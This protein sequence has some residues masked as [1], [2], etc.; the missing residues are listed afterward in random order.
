MKPVSGNVIIEDLTSKYGNDTHYVV[1]YYVEKNLQFTY[2]VSLI[3][4]SGDE[5][6]LEVDCIENNSPCS[7][8]FS[9]SDVANALASMG[10]SLSDGYIRFTFVPYGSDGSF[11]YAITFTDELNVDVISDSV[12]F[13]EYIGG[14]ERKSFSICPTESGYWIF[15][16]MAQYDSWAEITDKNGNQIACDDDN[17]YNSNFRIYQYLEA[18]KTYTINVR[19]LSWSLQG[20]MPLIFIFEG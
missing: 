13:V 5:I 14:D 10:L 18:G 4:E 3:D 15:T 20:N 12:S 7:I 17:G 9:K 1:G 2:Y 6:F 8:S 16:S 19:W 11:D